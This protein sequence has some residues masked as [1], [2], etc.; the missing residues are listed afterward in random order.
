MPS[1][2][3]GLRIRLKLYPIRLK[4]TPHK[5]RVLIGCRTRDSKFVEGNLVW[6]RP[7]LRQHKILNK[8]DGICLSI[9]RGQNY[10]VAVL[11]AVSVSYGPPILNSRCSM[12]EDALFEPC[13]VS[14]PS[15][16]PAGSPACAA[17]VESP[18]APSLWGPLLTNPSR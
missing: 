7:S 13:A 9:R 16:P 3:V 4:S 18:P 5:A 2:T 15:P 12:S 17:G 14:L 10:L 11:M 6:V 8:L 1:S